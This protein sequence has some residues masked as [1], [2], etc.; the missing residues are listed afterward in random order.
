MTWYLA[1]DDLIL[2]ITTILVV[3]LVAFFVY[4]V[5][6]YLHSKIIKL[7][8]KEKDLTWKLDV[9]NSSLLIAHYTQSL[10]MHGI[11]FIIQDLYKYTGE[12][13]CYAAKVATYYGNQ[14]VQGHTLV[15]CI[16]KYILI[17]HWEWAREFG[18]STITKMFFWINFFHPVVD[19]LIHLFITPNFFWAYDGYQQI[20]RCLGDPKHN[21]DPERN[22]SLTKLHNLCDLTDSNDHQE[23]EYSLHIIRKGTCWTQIVLFYCILGNF[24]EILLYS[25]I[26][27]FMR[28]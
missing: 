28:R 16:M 2:E 24:L 23:M 21:L 13:F 12:W 6:I 10:F 1:N 11:T 19:I 14:Y 25:R 17:V 5:G 26:F 7:S 8:M 27:W 20:D 4:T 22:K 3:P 9:T 18:Q 15:V